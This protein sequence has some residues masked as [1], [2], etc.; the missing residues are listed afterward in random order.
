[1]MAAELRATGKAGA[2]AGHGRVKFE[3]EGRA[4]EST[5]SAG[6]FAGETIVLFEA[7]ELAAGLSNCTIRA[8]WVEFAAECARSFGNQQLAILIVF[9]AAWSDG[10]AERAY[11]L[12]TR[13]NCRAHRSQSGQSDFDRHASEG[14]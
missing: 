2:G 3:G 13:S 6:R 12:T 4:S 10:L 8:E 14:W 9:R 1:M 7:L 11:S 5:P